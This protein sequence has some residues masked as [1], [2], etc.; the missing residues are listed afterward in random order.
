[1]NQTPERSFAERC[2]SLLRQVP[3]GKVTTYGEIARALNCKA[4]RAVGSA[5]NKNPYAPEV[6][7]HRVVCSDGSLGGF[8]GGQP[9]KVRMLAAEGVTVQG[10]KIIDFSARLH[11]FGTRK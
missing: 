3:P 7:C 9:K 5:M 11:T 6:P 1:M 4:F 2:Y 8:N 10:G